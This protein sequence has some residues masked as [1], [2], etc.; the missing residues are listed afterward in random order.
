LLARRQAFQQPLEL[1][2]LDG[3]R[4]VLVEA[5][6]DGE[7]AVLVSAVAGERYGSMNW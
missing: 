1:L 7:L 3:L 5:G 2:Q 6:I 4:E